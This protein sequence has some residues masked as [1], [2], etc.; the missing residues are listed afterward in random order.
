MEEK[1][2]RIF[3]LF[4]RYGIKSMTM[5]KIASHLSISKKTLYVLADNKAELVNKV[6]LYYLQKEQKA[7]KTI[8]RESDNAIESMIHIAQFIGSHIQDLNSN[9]IY[10]LQKYYPQAWALMEEHRSGFVYKQIVNNIKSGIKE[11]LYKK[12]SYP[13]SLL[14]SI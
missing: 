8:A 9:A 11:E 2:I 14:N 7:A 13:M 3:Q 4:V 10:D 1:L 5:D 12:T 6:L